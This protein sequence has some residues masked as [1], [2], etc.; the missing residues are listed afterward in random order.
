MLLGA[1]FLFLSNGAAIP[2]D[3]DDDAGAVY[4][5]L[6]GP[7]T[8]VCELPVKVLVVSGSSSAGLTFSE[9]LSRFMGIQL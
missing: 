3:D 7:C 2:D 1:P 4:N 6:G 5:A 8:T 9:L